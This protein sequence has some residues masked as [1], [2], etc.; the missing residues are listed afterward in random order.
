MV[1]LLVLNFGPYLLLWQCFAFCIY[2]RPPLIYAQKLWSLMY[3]ILSPHIF[4]KP[5]LIFRLIASCCHQL[6]HSISTIII[7]CVIT[8]CENMKKLENQFCRNTNIEQFMT[9]NFQ[10]YDKLCQIFDSVHDSWQHKSASL[11]AFLKISTTHVEPKLL[12]GWRNFDLKKAQLVLVSNLKIFHF[13]II[14]LLEPQRS[15]MRK[16]SQFKIVFFSTYI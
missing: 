8:Y 15:S 2:E 7:L 3:M 14:F 5:V 16:R 4:G 11:W 1:H 9:A 12:M 13:P 10:I 6:W